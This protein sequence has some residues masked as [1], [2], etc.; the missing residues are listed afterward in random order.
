MAFSLNKTFLL[1]RLGKD[2]ETRS[3]NS[4]ST[5]TSFSIA[6]THGYKDKN[7]KW[8]NETTWHNVVAWNLSDFMKDQLKK[9]KNVLI[10]GRISIEEYEDKDG[11]KRKAIKI[12]ASDIIPAESN[13]NGHQN[14]NTDVYENDSDDDLPI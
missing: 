10:E 13:G 5:V 2:A 6:T 9:G 4:G 12:I 11:V 8:Q 1:G 3:L 14:H 7:D